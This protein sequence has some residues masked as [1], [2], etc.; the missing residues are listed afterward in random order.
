MTAT[1]CSLKGQ[2]CPKCSTLR[3][4]IVSVLKLV[5]PLRLLPILLALSTF[6][7]HAQ[8]KSL[9]PVQAGQKL[10]SEETRRVEVMI[11]SRSQMPADYTVQVGVP[12]ASDISGFSKL[13][14]SF[15]STQSSTRTVDF[16]ISNDGKTLAQIN[17][18]DLTQ[19]PKDKVSAAGR[20]S[21]GGPENAPVLIVAFDD[22]E[23]P[24]CA[25]MHAELFPALLDRYKN[26]V[27]IVYR[28][29]PLSQH[30]WAMRAAVDSNCV[31][32]QSNTGYW[33]YVD[34]VHAHASEIG[35]TDASVDKAKQALDK[36]A[37]D[38]GAKQKIDQPT[39][40]ACILK[41]DTTKVAASLADAESEA[42][43]VDSTPTL[44]IN[45]EKVEGVLPI[46]TVYT[47]IDR[48]LVAA[49]QTPPPPAPPPPPSA[50]PAAA[51]PT[52]PGS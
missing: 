40:T 18:F 1:R 13:P 51:T 15:T 48:A 37:M 4:I 23:C 6:G 47:V 50:A 36:L 12:E 24:F 17:R 28:D 19:D 52:K 33:N 11:R 39:L 27:R 16:L 9:G 14:V 43:H 31:G 26:Q 5:A 42:L 30:P 22:L 25:R 21:R 8:S 35:G 7:C 10:S 3:E 46:T 49:G 29:F 20:P 38:E 45:G 32:T 44:F 41:Q 2:F 34:Y